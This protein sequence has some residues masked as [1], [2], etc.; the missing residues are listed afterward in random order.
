MKKILTPLL[1]SLALSAV[2]PMDAY[3]VKVG[4]DGQPLYENTVTKQFTVVNTQDLEATINERREANNLS[5]LFEKYSTLTDENKTSLF[6]DFFTTRNLIET[7]IDAVSYDNLVKQ[8][9][10]LTT[11]YNTTKSAP[12]T[13]F[14]KREASAFLADEV[15]PSMTP[16][17]PPQS[18]LVVSQPSLQQSADEQPA[19]PIR[20]VDFIMGDWNR[21]QHDIQGMCGGQNHNDITGFWNNMD[22]HFKQKFDRDLSTFNGKTFFTKNKETSNPGMIHHIHQDNVIMWTYQV[23]MIQHIQAGLTPPDIY[24]GGQHEFFLKL[25]GTGVIP[26]SDWVEL[27]GQQAFNDAKI[28]AEKNDVKHKPLKRFL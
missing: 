17:A 28:A 25:W 24:R 3:A 22:G 16:V 18:A 26:E 9:E 2:A 12:F 23:Y 20:L 8:E 4:L 10:A 19:A 11:I 6:N 7:A 27:Y 5:P 15:I 13:A 1:L 21:Y 14:L